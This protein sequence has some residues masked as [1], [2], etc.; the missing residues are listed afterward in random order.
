M[1]SLCLPRTRITNASVTAAAAYT[2]IE[3]TI[4]TTIA[5]T[6]RGVS[7]HATTTCI[8]LIPLC[9]GIFGI[10]AKYRLAASGH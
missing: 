1:S 8:W 10:T 7:T 6:S 4:R 9:V 3:S 5:K 2:A